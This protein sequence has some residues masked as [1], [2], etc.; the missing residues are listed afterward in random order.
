M[1]LLSP[2]ACHHVKGITHE[3]HEQ[4]NANTYECGQEGLGSRG[5]LRLNVSPAQ[6]AGFLECQP[7]NVDWDKGRHDP[8]CCPHKT[9]TS[10]HVGSALRALQ[11]KIQGSTCPTYKCG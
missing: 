11:H 5:C 10:P 4:T 8:F 6:H 1:R 7:T 3:G 9:A 2:P